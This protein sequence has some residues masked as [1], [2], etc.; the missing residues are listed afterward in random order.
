MKRKARKK[1]VL[2]CETLRALDSSSLRR[3][4]GA[5][6]ETGP[7]VCTTIIATECTGGADCGNWSDYWV[8]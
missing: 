4:F 3:V 1:L 8:C 6:P 5:A 2:H 7:G